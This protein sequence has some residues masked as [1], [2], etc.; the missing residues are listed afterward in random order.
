MKPDDRY[1]SLLQFYGEKHGVNWRFL[2]AQ[3]KQESAFDPDAKSRAGARGLAQFMRRTWE[4][5]KDGSPGIQDAPPI[6]LV[7]LDP[8]DPE[9]SINAQAAYMAWLLKL[10]DGAFEIALAA[11]NA[12]PTFVRKLA[13][14]D[15]YRS[16][17]ARLPKETRIYVPRVMGYFSSYSKELAA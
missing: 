10:F 4:E 13:W 9:D 16:I 14:A 3:L 17:A 8:R 12:G 15:G 2:K 7:M 11:Y 1:D 5:W 6:D